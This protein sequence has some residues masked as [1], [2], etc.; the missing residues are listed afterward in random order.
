MFLPGVTRATKAMWSVVASQRITSHHS[1]FS[2]LKVMSKGGGKVS[3]IT[4]STKKSRK[5]SLAPESCKKVSL[6]NLKLHRLRAPKT[7]CCGLSSQSSA[8]A[9]LRQRPGAMS[10]QSRLGF[11]AASRDALTFPVFCPT[12]LFLSTLLLD[13]LSVSYLIPSNFLFPLS[14][15]P[16]FHFLSSSFPLSISSLVHSYFLFS[17][18]FT[19]TFYFLTHSLPLSI[20]PLLFP[21][22]FHSS[23][24]SLPFSIPL[25]HSH[26]LF[27]FSLSLSIPASLFYSPFPLSLN[28]IRH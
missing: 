27:P 9:T 1:L 3:Q 8:A 11:S 5:R 26:F 7:P 12:P 23:S 17:L 21:P 10:Q 13:S 4:A 22:T 2:L 19:S 18:S 20:S 14:F 16:T 6:T 24:H 28:D 25:I 15:T